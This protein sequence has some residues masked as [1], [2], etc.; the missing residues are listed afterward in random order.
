MY[1]V[2]MKHNYGAEPELVPA[3]TLDSAAR[4][5]HGFFEGYG[6]EVSGGRPFDYGN[7]LGGGEGFFCFSDVKMHGDLVIGFCHCDGEG[8][9][10]H[11]VEAPDPV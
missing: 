10:C 8:P 11:V 2:E 9:I 7:D 4:V 1:I 6:F 5:A 3:K